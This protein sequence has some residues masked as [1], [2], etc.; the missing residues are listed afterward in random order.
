M[1]APPRFEIF[2][3][4]IALPEASGGWC[5]RCARRHSLPPE[6]AWPAALLLMERLKRDGR[7][8]FGVTAAEA[9]PRCATAPLFAE[10]GGKMFGVLAC[11]D[12]QGRAVTLRAYSGQFGGLWEVAGWAAPIFDPAAFD[13]LTRETE[14][15]IKRLGVEIERSVAGSSQRQ[16]LVRQRRSLSRDLMRQVHDLYR[17]VN[18]RGEQRLLIDAFQ[19][20]NLPPSGTGDC[21]A[22]KLLHHAALHDLSPEGLVEFYWGRSNASGSRVHGGLYPACEAR[23]RP[24]LGFMLC[25]CNGGENALP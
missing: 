12:N 9:D 21:C 14:G 20:D 16:H 23:C 17:L 18:F 22:T 15:M 13:H 7:I 10:E 24:V 5:A 6:P 4:G 25:G 19:G 3:A 11:R 2:A 8:D 1:I